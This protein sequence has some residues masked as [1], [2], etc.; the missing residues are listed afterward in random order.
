MS[1]KLSKPKK[2]RRARGTGTIF[3]DA[4]RG[5]YVAK[6]LIGR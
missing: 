1:K 3:P 5:G 4:R 6:V 2:K